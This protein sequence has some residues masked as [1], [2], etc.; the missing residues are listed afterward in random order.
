MRGGPR[1]ATPRD[2]HQTTPSPPSAEAT[3]LSVTPG[4]DSDPWY[5]DLSTVREAA[6]DIPVWIGIWAARREP[7]AH[8]RRCASDA[9]SAADTALAAL[10]RVRA[11]LVA[12]VRQA[13]DRAAERADTLLAELRDRRPS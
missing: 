13:D 3:R 11:R 12:E 6:E 8:A 5:A 10:H 7:D 2:R 4:G 9:I 1:A